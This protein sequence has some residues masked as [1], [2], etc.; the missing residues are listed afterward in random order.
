V[1]RLD[2]GVVGALESRMGVAVID[3]M[4]DGN[5]CG[6]EKTTE[7]QG[8]DRAEDSTVG[9]QAEMETDERM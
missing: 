5:R 4:E 1:D 9:V 6:S 3:K 2:A 8:A 7:E